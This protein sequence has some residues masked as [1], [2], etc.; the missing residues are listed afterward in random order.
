MKL[1][2]FLTLAAVALALGACTETKTETVSVTDTLPR[3]N[4]PKDSINGFLGY[5]A[6][7]TKQTQCGQCH[8]GQQTKWV[9]TQHAVAWSAL[10]SSGHA[11]AS[12]YGCHSVSQIGNSLADSTPAGY[13]K[14]AD[15]TY[16][17]VQCESCHGPG[18][19]P[20]NSHAEA[21]GISN[22]PLARLNV[23]ADTLTAVTSGT[24]AACHQGTHEPYTQEWTQ[25]AHATVQAPAI[26]NASCMGCHEGRN[27]LKAWNVTTNYVEANDVVTTANAMPVTC[28]I[29]HDPHSNAK[30]TGQLRWAIDDPNPANNLCMQCHL[31]GQTPTDNGRGP[32][33]P[34]GAML[35]GSAGWWPTAV[36]TIIATHGNV[37]INTRLCA[38][39]HVNRVTV[40]DTAGGFVFQSVGHLFSP[41]ACVDASGKPTAANCARPGDAG[42]TTG[43]RYFTGCQAAGCHNSAAQAEQAMESQRAVVAALA[44]A[45]WKD[46]NNNQVLFTTGAG[47]STRYCKGT[48]GCFAAFDPGDTGL[49]TELSAAQA[50]T[51]FTTA[52]AIVSVAE[53]VFFNVRLVGENRYGGHADG[54]F[55]VHNPLLTQQLLSVSVTAMQN[56]YGVF[57]PPAIQQMVAQVSQKVAAFKAS[58]GRVSSR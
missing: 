31:R 36:D 26:G 10:Q 45:L 51:A 46:N 44:D 23:P 39:C 33:A 58:Q 19:V 12:C 50:D 49:L 57:A 4:A 1:S 38:G 21:P 9:A 8:A 30:G 40:T 11:G 54:S 42:Y 15:S 28:G 7:A 3:F 35:L 13:T 5:Y 27:T 37:A 41:D 16:F 32:H 2:R 6:V 29:C 55:G 52:D 43:M 17:D 14:V 56:R 48:S 47:S 25:S 24:C 18:S 20:G 22:H 34:Q 53:G